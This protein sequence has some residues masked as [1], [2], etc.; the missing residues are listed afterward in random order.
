MNTTIFPHLPAFLEKLDQQ[1]INYTLA[2]YREDALSVL[3]ALPGERWE[4][5]FMNDGSIEIEKFISTGEI[6]DAKGLDELFDR[7]AD[8]ANQTDEAG[9][10]PITVSKVA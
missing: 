4:I 6:Y 9:D 7:Y 1:R 2:H 10:L 8:S 5:D 3:V